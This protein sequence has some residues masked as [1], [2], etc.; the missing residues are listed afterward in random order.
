MAA[1]PLILG[2]VGM[3]G[4]GK[5]TVAQYLQKKYK[6]DSIH[7]GDFIWDWLSRRGIKPTEE[8]GTMAA[9]YMWAEYGDIPLAKWA[10]YRIKQ[11]KAK[12]ILLD[13]LRTVEEARFFQ[14]KFGNSFHVIAVLAA[15]AARLNRSERRARFGAISKLEFRIR[16]REELRLG[17]GDLIASAN[18]Y[19]DA[20][21]TLR[22]MEK[23]VDVL[24]KLLR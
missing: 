22:E 23:Q 2:I 7:L 8:A 10:F 14:V 1:K 5:S 9:L 21:K 19:I 17:V 20:N 12:I 16:D 11:S 13:S 18:H 3:P 4:S 6:A 24:I 15:P